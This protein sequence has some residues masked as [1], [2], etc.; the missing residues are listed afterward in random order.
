[1]TAGTAGPRPGVRSF[2]AAAQRGDRFLLA[3]N[4]AAFPFLGLELDQRGPGSWQQADKLR[5]RGSPSDE[6]SPSV[7]WRVTWRRRFEV[8]RLNRNCKSHPSATVRSTAPVGD[9]HGGAA[10][11]GLEGA[12]SSVKGDDRAVDRLFGGPERDEAWVHASD[13][14]SYIEIVGRSTIGGRAQELRGSLEAKPRCRDGRLRFR[15]RLGR[16]GAQ[17][18]ASA[19]CPA[20]PLRPSGSSGTKNTAKTSATAANNSLI[21]LRS[22]PREREGG[23]TMTDA[24]DP[25]TAKLSIKNPTSSSA[26]ATPPA[27]AIPSGFAPED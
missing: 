6:P 22:S 25:T 15:R 2:P 20:S 19:I 7:R 27:P 26:S 1:M 3:R 4:H 5:P 13:L 8:R 9:C 16:R 18:T 11:E 12:A 23:R 14:L 21:C 10:V 17:T 24:N